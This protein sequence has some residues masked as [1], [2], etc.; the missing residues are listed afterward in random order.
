MHKVHWDHYPLVA[1]N[2]FAQEWLEIQAKIGLA[3]NTVEAYGRGKTLKTGEK[4]STLRGTHPGLRGERH[5]LEQTR[6]GAWFNGFCC[7]A[8]PSERKP[9]GSLVSEVIHTERPISYLVPKPSDGKANRKLIAS[10]TSS[11]HRPPDKEERDGTLLEEGP[12]ERV[13]NE[14]HGH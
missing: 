6:E 10:E 13:E 2:A 5:V 9:P 4:N 8:D 14:A 7:L 11:T 3:P 12:F 1:S